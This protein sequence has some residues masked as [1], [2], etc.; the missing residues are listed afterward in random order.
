MEMTLFNVRRAI[1]P[2]VGKS[3]LRFMCSARHLIMLY[4]CVKFRENVSNGIRVL[5]RTRVHCRNG[6]VQCSKDNNSVSRQIGVT[7]HVFCTLS[8]DGLHW[9][10]VS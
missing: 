4:I 6:Y 7:V 3:E 2:T 5:E 9:C 8:H 1:T 10:E